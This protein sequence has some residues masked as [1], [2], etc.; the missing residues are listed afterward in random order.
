[1]RRPSGR[2]G[3]ALL[4]PFGAVGVYVDVIITGTAQH[5]RIGATAAVG[6][7]IEAVTVPAERNPAAVTQHDGIFFIADSAF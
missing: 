6:K 2:T 4:R 3:H 5:Q 1:M 7:E